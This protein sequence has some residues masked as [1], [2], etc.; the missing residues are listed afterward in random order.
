MVKKDPPIPKRGH[1][2]K[3]ARLSQAKAKSKKAARK[4]KK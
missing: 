2:P 1:K 4:K 3:A